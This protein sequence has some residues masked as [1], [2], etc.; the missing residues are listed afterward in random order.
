M[1]IAVVFDEDD[2]GFSSIDNK[3]FRI[4]LEENLLSSIIHNG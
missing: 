3:F 2:D 1:R 4:L